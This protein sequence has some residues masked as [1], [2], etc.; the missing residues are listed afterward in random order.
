M[1]SADENVICKFE[2]DLKHNGATNVAILPL[3]HDHDQMPD[4]FVK[5]DYVFS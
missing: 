2:N 3:E 4:T 1:P 5:A